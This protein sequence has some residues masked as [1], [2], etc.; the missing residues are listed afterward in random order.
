M[1]K[2]ELLVLAFSFAV[3]ASFVACGG[4]SSGS[5]SLSKNNAKSVDSRYLLNSKTELRVSVC[6][7]TKFE[8]RPGYDEMEATGCNK[9]KEVPYKDG[10]THKSERFSALGDVPPQAP[11]LYR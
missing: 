10:T 1:T 2:K 11:T 6:E 8:K 3:A 9:W 4:S 7:E 5:T